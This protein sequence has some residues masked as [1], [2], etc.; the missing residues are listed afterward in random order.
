MDSMMSDWRQARALIFDLFHTL[1]SLEVAKAPGQGT[2]Q[3][4]GIDPDV[5]YQHWLKDPPDYVLGLVP[6][7]V[8]IRHL[9][10]KLNPAVTEAQL[11]E[12]LKTRHERFRHTLTHIEPETLD[13]LRHLRSLEFRLGLISNCGFDEVA[14][15]DKSPLAPLF[16][17][18]V[19]SCSVKMKKPDKEIYLYTAEKLGVS[20]R[21]CL[22]VGNGGSDELA[23]AERAGMTPV[24]LT[25]HLEAI[26]P[27]Q[28]IKVMPFAR[29]Y[30]RTVDDLKFMLINRGT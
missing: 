22:Y 28:I 18:T 11:Q 29:I 14:H 1:V 27:A 9:A 13:A 7:D 6:V 2:P 30:V 4:L 23:G 20:P 3:I 16:D 21:E 24:L 5:W 10:R 19:F 15:W 8:P 25:R 12:A 26:R 17:T